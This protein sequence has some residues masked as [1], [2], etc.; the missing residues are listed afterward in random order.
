[1]IKD[2]YTGKEVG[3]LVKVSMVIGAILGVLTGYS[4]AQFVRFGVE[5]LN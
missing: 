3:D 4:F 2:N 1:M 5:W